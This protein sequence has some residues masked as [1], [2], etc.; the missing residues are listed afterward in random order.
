MTSW[1]KIVS[2]KELIAVKKQRNR[3]FVT[4]KERK[5][6]LEELL[7]EGWTE[8]KTYKDPKW[9]GVKKDKPY[10]ELFE[11]KVWLLF[12]N[13]GFAFMNADRSFK[14]QYD[15]QNPN[16]TQQIDVFVADDE[17][18]VIVECKSANELKEVSF[19]K[20]IEALH[21]Q[22][23]GLRKEALKKHPNRKVKFIW[24]T[25][26]IIMN[27]ADLAK[28]DEWNIAYFNSATIDYYMELVKH[29]GSC[30]RYQLLGNLFANQEISNMENKIP[31]IQGKMGGN[32]Y[33]SFSI[34][35][36]KLLKIGYVLH[37]NEANKRM[38][39]TYQRL[40]KKKRLTDVQNFVNLGG[41]FPN[42]IIISLDTGGKGLQFD[43][44]STKYETT[45]SKIGTLHLPRK[46]RSAYIIDG[47]H[48]LYGYSGSK[49]ASKNTI[50]VVAFVD[51]A[52]EQ[53]I[54]LFMDINEN[55]KAVSKSLRV[56]L[57]ADMLWVSDD[58]NEQ[59]QALRSKIAQKLGEEDTSPLFGRVVVGENEKTAIK[60]I[61]IEALQAALK[62]CNFFTIYGKNNAIQKDGTFDLGNNDSTI[63]SFYPFLEECLRYIK[64]NL[65]DEWAKEEN[66][67]GLLTINRGIQGIIRL[68][69]DVVNH[70]IM[71]NKISPKE[72]KTEE[73]FSE[74][75]YYLD[76]LFN[77]FSEITPEHRKDLRSFFGGGADT[78]FLRTFQKAVADC[79]SDFQPE[80]LDKYWEDESKTYNDESFKMIQDIELHFSRDF[81]DRLK[82]HYDDNWFVAGVPKKVYEFSTKLAAE[83]DYE[84]RQPHGTTDPWDCLNIIHYR[85][86]AS[87]GKNWRELFERSYTRP[88]EEH[89]SREDKTVWMVNLNTIRNSLFHGRYSVTKEQFEFLKNLH[90]WLV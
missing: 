76:P 12:A 53:Q 37:R 56:T 35:P 89:K 50:P 90:E 33:Y 22:M 27:K 66:E 1:E 72:D 79:R 47:Q 19:K 45:I 14:M 46:Y 78:R 74:V 73:I 32:T 4:K 80:G 24:A 81:K 3:A 70:L 62:R 31:A 20:P 30:A 75:I 67:N 25:N 5:V 71:T 54:Q 9:I 77:F 88:G 55:Q 57:H 38:M 59:R 15:F 43:L 82:K 41:Y 64:S 60:C 61:T 83:K 85:D 29:I 13:L 2:E 28:L 21:G 69:N 18:V 86:I 44:A 63:E 6:A 68:I 42:S 16:I 26:N 40:I 87:Y 48:R 7:E 49:Y 23:D 65:E 58:Y 10:D 34:E 17:T 52:R 11:D 8:F 36:E 51:L 39:P 84:K